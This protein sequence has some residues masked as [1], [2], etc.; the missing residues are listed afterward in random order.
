MKD[1]PA[2]T[3]EDLQTYLAILDDNFKMGLAALALFG[4]PE[5]RSLLKD[6]QYTSEQY[7]LREPADFTYMSGV[8]RVP[9]DSD[10]ITEE[11]AKMCLRT[12]VSE[13]IEVVGSYCEQ[14]DGGRTNG[15]TMKLLWKQHWYKFGRL[16]RNGLSHHGVFTFA[17]GS[18][19]RDRRELEKEPVVWRGKEITLEMEGEYATFG[20]FGFSDAQE[21]F[22]EIRLFVE[23]ELP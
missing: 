12:Y 17:N 9:F 15:P 11:F 21:M 23:N 14:R 4:M 19:D 2:T 8:L 18:D 22:Q 10:K 7:G 3:K 6:A 5:A 16:V 13:M 1:R 20:L